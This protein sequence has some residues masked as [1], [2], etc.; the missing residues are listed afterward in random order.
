[1]R[2]RLYARNPNED[3]RYSGG[4]VVKSFVL[5]FTIFERAFLFAAAMLNRLTLLLAPVALASVVLYS[6]TKR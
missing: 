2:K 1:L 6:Y 5:G 4:R 3:A